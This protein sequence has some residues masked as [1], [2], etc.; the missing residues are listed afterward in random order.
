MLKRLNRT[1]FIR[2]KTHT[3]TH[4]KKELG[5]PSTRSQTVTEATDES[6]ITEI[7]TVVYI[8]IVSRIKI[9]LLALLN[10]TTSGTDKLS[11]HVTD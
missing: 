5:T 6:Y 1:V 9:K 7:A 8:I 3:H 4:K 10:L 2:T 11:I